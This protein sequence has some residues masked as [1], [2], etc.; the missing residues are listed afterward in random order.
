[1]NTGMPTR[2][3]VIAL[4]AA[5][6][7]I[8]S[9]ALGQ[10]R[11]TTLKLA[12]ISRSIPQWELFEKFKAKV[13]ADSGHKLAIDLTTTTDL[14]VQ[15][16][17]LIRLLQTGLI[18]IANVIPLHVS[19]TVPLLEA[20]ELPGIFPDVETNRKAFADWTQKV[21]LKREALVGGRVVG[22][23]GWAGQMLFARKPIES[24]AELKG[25]KIRVTSRS[26]SDYVNALGGAPVTISLD[27]LYT[28]LQQGT[29][30]GATTAAATGFQ[31]RLWETTKYLIDLGIGTPTGLLVVAS[32]VWSSLSPDLQK[33]VTTAGDEFTQAGW[34][35]S[36]TLE[37]VGLDQNQEKGV[38]FVPM[39]PEWKPQL[40]AAQKVVAQKW[41]A[42]AGADAKTAFNTVLS[43]YTKFKLD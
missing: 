37:K 17:D 7:T 11:P 15:S 29:V 35:Q 39:K 42:R 38:K 16:F 41:A 21:L 6:T 26:M 33:V 8:S 3:S 10:S 5:S 13:E 18:D 9:R 30:D 28:G 32:N 22:S 12:T 40:E 25:S 23:F 20:T 19:G 2:R 4:L 24:L 43:P 31:M 1:M 34:T 14:G 27:E 36:L